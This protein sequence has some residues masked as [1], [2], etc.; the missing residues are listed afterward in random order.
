[1]KHKASKTDGTIESYVAQDAD[2]GL[3]FE[4]M[5]SVNAQSGII[6]ATIIPLFGM[7]ISNGKLFIIPNETKTPQG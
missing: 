6:S 1:M 2:S 5:E 7:G 3:S 4:V